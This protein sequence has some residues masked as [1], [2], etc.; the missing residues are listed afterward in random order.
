MHAKTLLYV[1]VVL[2]VGYY[3]GVK[4]PT[5]GNTLASKVGL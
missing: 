2:V 4:Y 3:I 5:V 1:A